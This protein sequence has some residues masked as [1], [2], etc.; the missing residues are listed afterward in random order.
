VG[1]FGYATDLPPIYRD[2]DIFVLPSLA[3]G[4]SMSALE[5]MATG[6]AVVATD[7][8]GNADV[9]AGGE[10]G[11]LVPSNDVAALT[12]ALDLLVADSAARHALGRA[13][14]ARAVQVY[15]EERVIDQYEELYLRRAHTAANTRPVASL[16]VQS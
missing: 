10:A 16:A 6:L 2:F 3:E 1:F 14:R 9:L 13:A 11:R 7:V 15:E 4:T 12:D 8:G 5:A